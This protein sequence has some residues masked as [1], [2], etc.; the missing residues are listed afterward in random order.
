[1]TLHKDKF[2]GDMLDK[3]NPFILKK[4]LTGLNWFDISQF[5]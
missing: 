2:I 4:T 1:M 3:K 5:L